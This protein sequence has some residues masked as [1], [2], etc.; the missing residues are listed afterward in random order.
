MID[1]WHS[2]RLMSCNSPCN[3]KLNGF[4]CIRSTLYE[5]THNK[6]HKASNRKTTVQAQYGTHN[7][8]CL[9]SS[10]SSQP[11]I[12]RRWVPTV[13][14]SGGWKPP[15]QQSATWR[16]LQRWLFFGT[17]SKLISFPDHF[18]SN[19]LR[20]LVQYTIYSSGLAVL[21][22]SHSK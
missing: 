15:L 19:C 2:L 14:I 3:V 1:C 5:K 11:V 8:R 6:K 7:C 18:L 4:D 10:L 13:G 9:Q 17:A 16:H 20:F 22:L 12:Q 21:Y